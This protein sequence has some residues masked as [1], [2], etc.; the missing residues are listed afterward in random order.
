MERL[1]QSVS[2]ADDT[3]T[4]STG[5]DSAMLAEQTV[6]LT[7]AQKGALL[8][9]GRQSR[10]ERLSTRKQPRSNLLDIGDGELI[11]RW[12]LSFCIDRGPYVL[13]KVADQ[14][15]P[16]CIYPS[17]RVIEVLETDQ[18]FLVW[19][20]I[21]MSDEAHTYLRHPRLIVVVEALRW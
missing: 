6:G 9:T 15:P 17:C 8:R 14:G 12:L 18:R 4:P 5:D 16:A 3:I 20:Q 7:T 10:R 2:R 11:I 21:G 13:D 19:R 1:D